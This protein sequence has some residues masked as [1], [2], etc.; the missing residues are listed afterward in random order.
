M[1]E[2]DLGGI[3]TSTLIAMA[4]RSPDLHEALMNIA[5]AMGAAEKIDARRLGNW[6]KTQINAIA[7][8][9]KLEVNRTDHSRPWW[10][11]VAVTNANVPGESE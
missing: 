2:L 5:P 4:E 3:T 1:K 6:L 8:G 10:K 7:A 11:L 9:H